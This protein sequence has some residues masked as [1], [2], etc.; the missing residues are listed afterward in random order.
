MGKGHDVPTTITVN[1]TP[2]FACF[3]PLARD[4]M[5]DADACLSLNVLMMWDM[6]SEFSKA[7][8]ALPSSLL[9]HLASPL[10]GR[11]RFSLPEQESVFSVWRRPKKELPSSNLWDDEAYVK[12][13]DESLKAILYVRVSSW[14]QY[15]LEYPRSLA[16]LATSN[17]SKVLLYVYDLS[18]GLARQL[19]LPLTGKF[20]E[21]IWHTSV[22][23]YGRE[24]YYG[25]G[26][27][28]SKPGMTHVSFCLSISYHGLT[29]ALLRSTV[30]QF[31]R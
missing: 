13:E 28:E 12:S 14:Y 11:S 22:V 18:G 25:Q 10:A 27:L 9:D 21:G 2:F 24:V 4:A 16:F 23:V 7:M 31:E 19:S 30:N 29:P 20:I 17:M 5:G 8:S 6:D 15:A 1:W 3:L 26:I